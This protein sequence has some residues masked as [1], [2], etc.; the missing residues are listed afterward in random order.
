MA[1]STINNTNNTPKSKVPG[2]ISQNDRFLEYD[3]KTS[4]L[5]DGAST[6]NTTHDLVHSQQ[7]IARMNKLRKAE[8]LCDVTLKVEQTLFP[9]H[10]LV[11]AAASDYFAAMFTGEMVERHMNVIELKGF[12]ASVME[13]LLN[14]IYGEPVIVTNDNVQDILPAA[15]LLQLNGTDIQ[16]QCALFLAS[17]LEPANC[18]GIYCFADLHNC[19]QLKQTALSF[20][21]THFAAVVHSEEFLTLK[22]N[23]VEDLIQ[24]DEIEVPNEEIIYNCVMAWI[25]H[26]QTFRQQYLLTL[27]QHVR[28]PFLSA[29]FITDICDNELLIRS[30]HKC[31]DL[32]DEAKRYHLRPDCRKLLTGTRFTS[33]RDDCQSSSCSPT[34]DCFE[35]IP[36]PNN[37]TAIERKS[38]RT[39]KLKWNSNEL[40]NIEPIFYVIEAQWTLPK[41]DINQEDIISKWGF[42]K[43][44]VSHTKAIIRNIQR[45]NRWYTFR[46]ATVT[47]HGYSPFSITTKPFRLNSQNESQKSLSITAAPRNLFIKDF[48]L[49]SNTINVT[50][51]W[52]KPDLPI[53]GYQISWEAQNDPS[54]LVNTIDISSSLYPLELTISFLSMHTS[55]IFKIRSL[56]ISDDDDEIQMSVPLSIKFNYE[57]E[58]LSIRNFYISEPYFINGLIKTNI[59]WN[60]IN[61]YRIQQYDLHWIE[62]Q[63]SSDI[64]PCCY[65][66]DAVTID[67][68]FQLYDL[69]FN[70]TY[71]LNI[72][73]IL[74]KIRIKKSFQIYFNVSSCQLIQVY[75]TIRPPCQIDEN[76]TSSS[77]SPL[78][79]II[80]RNESGIQFYW[81]DMRLLV[82]DDSGIIYQLHIEQLPSHIELISVDLSPTITNYFLPYSKQQ[83]DRYLNVTLTLFDNLIIQQQKSII[84]DG[85]Q[86]YNNNHINR[87]T[88][89]SVISSTTKIQMNYFI[90]FIIFISIDL[91]RR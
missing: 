63:C 14:S 58:L 15:S 77:L 64:L 20:I 59:S 7:L 69:R 16:R 43:E 8:H 48:Q 34:N 74:S 57:D 91:I 83:G 76:L 60:K 13:I 4:N 41:T 36:Q 53:N 3:S 22:A 89:L 55:Y 68:F 71:L 26:D 12:S 44:E 75:G 47:R 32:L 33:R 23:E 40:T 31:R 38:R 87:N 29:R 56:F 84:I 42:V 82:H 37:I 28:L 27:L 9:A 81:Q 1:S 11:L 39:V 79:L 54:L 66:R 2:S 61:D 73:P 35:K 24:S 6:A 52:Q 90:L 18:L 10:R 70:C 50:L 46:V 17:H 72:K 25:K 51:S 49:N 80:T 67:N 86:N 65:R 85:Y 5:V 78:N 45:D 19:S 30:S 88:P 21:W 62:T